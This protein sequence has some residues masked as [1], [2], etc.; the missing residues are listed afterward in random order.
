MKNGLKYHFIYKNSIILVSV[1]KL[2]GVKFERSEYL[3]GREALMKGY[4]NSDHCFFVFCESPNFIKVQRS[5]TSVP[6]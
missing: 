1:P 2:G 6:M 3:R 5:N 4:S